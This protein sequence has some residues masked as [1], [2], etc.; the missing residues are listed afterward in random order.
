MYY[1]VA[2]W[3]YSILRLGGKG[4][5]RCAVIIPSMGANVGCFGVRDLWASGARVK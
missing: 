4:C 3:L 2:R 1:S 5:A